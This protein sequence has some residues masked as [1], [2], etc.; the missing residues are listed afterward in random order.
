[1]LGRLGAQKRPGR[2]EVQGRKYKEG[3]KERMKGRKG[4][5][6]FACGWQAPV[7]RQAIRRLEIGRVFV[8]LSY[9][10][11][12]VCRVLFCVRIL[13]T[14]TRGAVEELPFAA[15]SRSTWHK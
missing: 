12:P 8:G 4:G 10:G 13:G 1:M 5:L 15:L 3:S 6:V 9:W 7:L 2:K 14:P 11:N